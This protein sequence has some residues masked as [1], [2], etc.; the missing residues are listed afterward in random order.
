ME[1]LLRYGS[2]LIE[3]IEINLDLFFSCFPD[4]EA[5]GH[6]ETTNDRPQ[7]YYNYICPRKIVKNTCIG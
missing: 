2:I 3:N 6:G 1:I 7:F 4:F 5:I